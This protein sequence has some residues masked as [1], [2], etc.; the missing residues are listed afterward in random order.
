MNGW[1]VFRR[2]PLTIKHQTINNFRHDL[3][4]PGKEFRL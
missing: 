4:L 1:S 2:Q 3:A